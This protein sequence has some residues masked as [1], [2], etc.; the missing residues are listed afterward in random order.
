[1]DAAGG[2]DGDGKVPAVPTAEVRLAR[3]RR[4]ESNGSLA[5]LGHFRHG[6]PA[7]DPAL[8]LKAVVNCFIVSAQGVDRHAGGRPGEA[9][10]MEAAV[11]RGSHVA[12]DGGTHQAV[13]LRLDGRGQLQGA[14]PAVA[15]LDL[16]VDRVR[17]DIEPVG[18]TH[19]AECNENAVEGLGISQGREDTR[20][21]GGDKPRHVYDAFEAVKEADAQSIA[22]Q[23]F[24]TH[25]APRHDWPNGRRYG[26]G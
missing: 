9:A 25:H 10:R 20:V 21:R 5:P 17:S 24:D 19:S 23:C 4:A 12:N 18:P 14:L 11:E 15:R 8:G 22:S 16:R 1:M 2:I 3:Q 13:T 6:F 26:S 7:D